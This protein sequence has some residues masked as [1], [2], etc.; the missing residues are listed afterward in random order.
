[1]KTKHQLQLSDYGLTELSQ[2]EQRATHGGGIID[3][4]WWAFW[5]GV[6]NALNAVGL[7]VVTN[8]LTLITGAPPR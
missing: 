5:G 8:L 6:Y 4:V 1:M 2:D 7:Q 3:G